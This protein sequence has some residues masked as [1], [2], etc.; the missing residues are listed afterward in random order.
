MDVRFA[1]L[2]KTPYY[3]VVFTA[4]LAKSAP[5]YAKMADE[6]TTLAA[7][8]PGYLGLESTRDESGLGITVS[9]WKDEESI[10]N[11]KAQ[12]DHNGAQKLGKSQWYTAY[13]LRVCK[14]E[15]NYSGPEGR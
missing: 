7:Q 5:G 1:P 2:F 4:K 6:M 3:A 14:V 12:I 8:Q 9:Y 15:R 11:W 10:R 13:N